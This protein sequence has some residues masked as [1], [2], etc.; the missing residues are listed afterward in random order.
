MFTARARRQTWKEDCNGGMKVLAAAEQEANAYLSI[1]LRTHA[2]PRVRVK[3][4]RVFLNGV[5]LGPAEI[6]AERIRLH[7][8]LPIHLRRR[9]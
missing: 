2:R 6:Y 5:Q 4:G 1:A 9:F 3:G 8:L 7:R